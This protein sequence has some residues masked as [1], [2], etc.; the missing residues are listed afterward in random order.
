[1][2]E[3]AEITGIECVGA[4]RESLDGLFLPG[5]VAMVGGMGRS[6][7]G[8]YEEICM[9]E[10]RRALTIL[11]CQSN[12][13]HECTYLTTPIQKRNPQANA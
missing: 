7:N 2:G 8:S 4:V 10:N 11:F 5:Q 1:L 9:R 13:E 6:I 12:Q 3:V